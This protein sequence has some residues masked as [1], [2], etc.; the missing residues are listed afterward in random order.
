[1]FAPGMGHTRAQ[2]DTPALLKA[3]AAPKGEG[4]DKRKWKKPLQRGG[5]GASNVIKSAQSP[6]DAAAVVHA[7]LE[8]IWGRIRAHKKAEPFRKPVTNREAPDYG[9]VIE[10]PMALSDVE[11]RLRNGR[12]RGNLNA[13]FH[14]MGLIFTNAMQYNQETSDIHSWARELQVRSRGDLNMKT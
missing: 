12:Y 11:K 9:L 13:F 6:P 3:P 14:D 7:R 1:M 10:Q 5:A 2:D 4:G 8:A